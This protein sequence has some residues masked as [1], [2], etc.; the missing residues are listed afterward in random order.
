RVP[1]LR[2]EELAQ[3]AGVSAGYYT[4]LEQGRSP[5][6]SDAVLTAIARV[7]RLDGEERDHLFALA[8]PMIVANKNPAQPERLRPQALSMLSALGDVPALIVGRSADILA[9]NPMAHALLAGHLDFDAPDDPSRR[10]NSARL[11]FLDEHTR[12]LYADWWDK[13]RDTVA[14][15][16]RTAALYPDD[17]HLAELVG[18]LT[19]NSEEFAAL[20]SAH[21]VRPC[22]FYTRRMRHPLVGSFTLSNETLNLP[23]DDGQRLALFHAAP[24]SP[25]ESALKLLADL[26]ADT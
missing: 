10:P 22:G 1:G 16:R 11:V 9:W 3:L 23:G 18:E 13:A 2:R 8:R 4:R 19:M 12:E 15:L 17:R 5:N 20:W 7:L 24:G 21:L 26:V 25:D 6:A 14:D